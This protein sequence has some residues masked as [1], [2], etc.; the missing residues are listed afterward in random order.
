MLEEHTMVETI[1]DVYNDE[2][3]T[4]FIK[5]TVISHC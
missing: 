1:N 5:I 3:Y 2:Y 4:N